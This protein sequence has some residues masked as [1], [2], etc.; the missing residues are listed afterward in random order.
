MGTFLLVSTS[1][2]WGFI[3]SLTASMRTKEITQK[4]FGVPF[5]NWYRFLY[6]LLSVATIFPLLALVALLPDVPLYTI[7][8]PWLYF[9]SVIQLLAVAVLVIGV[10]QTD[11]WSFIGLRQILDA[12]SDEKIVTNGLYRYV[13][14]PLYSAGLAFI[15]LMPA[16]TLNRFILYLCLTSYIFI[17]VYFEERKLVREFGQDYLEYRASTPMLIPL[18]FRS[19]QKI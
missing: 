19:K 10:L 2:L 6:N 7:P 16:M 13:R 17:G 4:A 3:H 12:K 11:V 5:M 14:H 9:T 18:S 8:V 15:W 1:V